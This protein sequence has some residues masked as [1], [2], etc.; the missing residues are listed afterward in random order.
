MKIIADLHLHSKY[1]RAVS[2][3]M[4]FPQMAEWARLKG[5]DLLGTSDFTHPLWLREAKTFLEEAGEGIYQ[6]KGTAPPGGPKF[7]FSTEVACI[8]KQ[9]EKGRRIHLVILAPSLEVVEKINLSLAGRG[10]NLLS[11]GRPIMGMS[12]RNF[13]EI[14]LS[15][16]EDALVIPAHCWT[17]WFS[18]FGSESGFDSL[19]ECFGDLSPY[20]YGVETGLS[21]SPAENWR[22]SQLDQC[23]ILSFSDAHSPAKMGREVTVFDL[24]EVSYK[25]VLAA[26]KGKEKAKILSTI[27]FYPEEGKYHWTGHRN[28]KVCQS[29]K[30]TKRLG[31]VCPVC[32]RKLTIGVMHRVE[33]LADRPPESKEEI[34]SS[35]LR[36]IKDPKGKRP[37]FVMMV[38]L[39]E[40]LTEALGFQ[41]ASQKV[42]AEYHRLVENFQGEFNVLLKVPF[43]ELE[44]ITSAPVVEAIKKVRGG[45]IVVEPGYDGVFGVVKIWQEEKKKEKETEQ[46]SLF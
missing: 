27:E 7:I 28:C 1:S 18:L 6:V 4:V 36:L 22:L 26:I 2:S 8:F 34:S 33:T 14:V 37:P 39:L 9:G 3:Q 5:I 20:I 21:S 40:I 13:T 12:A 41:S 42:V 16:S 44:K 25:N 45:E 17:P 30:E 19:E 23:Q 15:V 31:S 43:S 32:G 38:P 11:D 46:I 35:G 10:V 29:P 24:E